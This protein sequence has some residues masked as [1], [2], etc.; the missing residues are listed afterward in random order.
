MTDASRRAWGNLKIIEEG[1]DPVM[2]KGPRGM[3]NTGD[4]GPVWWQLQCVCGYSWR[5]YK[6]EFPGRSLLRDCGRDECTARV[7]RQPQLRP[8][9]RPLTP[10][11]ERGQ[12][13]QFYLK[14]T[15][16]AGLRVYAH[17]EH[18]SLS[19]AA[20]ALLQDG[21]VNHEI[22]KGRENARRGTQ[23]ASMQKVMRAGGVDSESRTRKIV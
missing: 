7:T 20:S 2:A 21:L 3:Y 16:V 17:D 6:A 8:L 11:S 18:L 4:Y 15:L 13:Y 5:V 23:K 10:Q 22:E 19:A 12:T 9:G 14:P 1:T